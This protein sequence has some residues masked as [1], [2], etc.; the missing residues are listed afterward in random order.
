LNVIKTNYEFN[1]IIKMSENTEEEKQIITS[2]S[3]A[4]P[5]EEK[6]IISTAPSGVLKGQSPLGLTG[7]PREEKQIIT[8]S[9][10][11]SPREEKQIISTA[12]SGV[13]KGQSPF[14]LKLSPEQI[15]ALDLFKKGENIFLTGPGGTGK[16]ELIK[17]I[18]EI[19]EK[20]S[21]P[22]QVCA[23]TGCAALLL[24]CS[25]SKTIHSWSGIGLASG[26]SYKVIDRVLKNKHKCKAWREIKV[27]VID[28]ISMMSKKVFDI[29]D[30]IGRSS[31]KKA[32]LP[33]GG[34]Q[35]VFSGDFYQL[36]PVGSGEED[37]EDS[38][39]FCFESS[40]WNEIFTT[41]NII[42][43]KTIFRQTDLRYT[44]ALNEIRV[45]KLY[46]S[47]YKLLMTRVGVKNTNE[48]IKPTILY[49]K[50]RDVESINSAEMAKLTGKEYVYNLSVIND[51]SI[52]NKNKKYSSYDAGASSS[53]SAADEVITEMAIKQLR[54]SIIADDKLVLKVGA[55][56][57][58]IA[59]IDMDGI[60]PVVN[61][62]QGV[63]IEIT[64]DG[65]PVVQFLNGNKRKFE[66]HVWTSEIN[67]AINIK[68]LPLIHAWA[69]TIH[70][71]QGVTLDL[72][73]IDAGNNI[74]E[75][76]QTYVALSRV[77]SLDGLY[78]TAFN[79]QKIKVNDKVQKYYQSI[80]PTATT[81]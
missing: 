50:R 42:Q 56:V 40:R 63:V 33:F 47:S 75:C 44:K 64:E 81:V 13:L 15:T 41:S 58:C 78:L 25:G 70:K 3:N 72:A 65:R 48:L 6:Q 74:F 22:I 1:I 52:G 4:S 31:R 60:Y 20:Q 66:Y 38:S 12:P 80:V 11:A 51:I 34:I 36:P 7:S 46:T 76:G 9:S 39:A 77:K 32:D 35:V 67:P 14:P 28:E 59:N 2:S 69:I 10:N 16:T 49:P 27:L 26:T 17:R 73:E 18:V 57:M 23:L 53:S 5:R 79:P 43:L 29:L 61:G 71:S 45:G 37:D 54:G 8:S 21:K 62:S 68:Q 55:Q 30:S 19:A 24:G